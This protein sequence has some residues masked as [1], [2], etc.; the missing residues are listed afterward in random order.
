MKI[1]IV[2]L[3]AANNY[4]AYLQAFA[5]QKYLRNCGHHPVFI[6][7]NA[8]KPIRTLLAHLK[9]EL[10]HFRLNNLF[11]VCIRHGG[12]IPYLNKFDY[13]SIKKANSLDMVILGSD[14]I[15]NT[16]RKSIYE[17]KVLF[18]YGINNITISYAPSI[19]NAKAEDF[20][21]KPE[22]I[23]MLKKI[24]CISVRDERSRKIIS[25]LLDRKIVTVVD[26]TLLLEKSKWES[27]EKK[28]LL[29][30]RFMMLYL[31]AIED[32]ALDFI[33]QLQD[34]ADEK[35]IITVS[36]FAKIKW[37]DKNIGMTP[38]QFLYAMHHSDV[39]VTDS[40]HGLMFALIY[41][42][43][44]IIPKAASSKLQDTIT[45][46]HLEDRV[47]SSERKV[48]NILQQNPDYNKI[49]KLM[50]YNVNSSKQYLSHC[51]QK[52]CDLVTPSITEEK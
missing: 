11:F 25:S 32:Y 49:N 37:A 6:K 40:F 27:F 51:V 33:E 9:N 44:F 17:N 43:N 45:Q 21:K 14:E 23:D 46:Y 3:Y 41:Q 30:T 47:F 1:G 50:N 18:G 52:I 4:G 26:P 8:R 36:S 39:V 19:N 13:C 7:H 2:T 5:L 24:D 20:Q 16:S 42:K 38:F 28:I 15:W 12:N 22:I 10:T 31:Y 29:P 48:K 34:Y 35:K